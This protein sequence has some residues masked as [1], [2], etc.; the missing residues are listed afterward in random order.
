[1]VFWVVTSN[2][3]SVYSSEILLSTTEAEQCHKSQ[4]NIS[5]MFP[6]RIKFACCLIDAA[7]AVQFLSADVKLGIQLSAYL[8]TL[9]YF[10]NKEC[11]GKLCVLDHRVRSFKFCL[12]SAV[13]EK[14]RLSSLLPIC[15]YLVTSHLVI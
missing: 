15:L 5:C 10:G 12:L 1:M 2:V 11:L 3:K 13:N 6:L 9:R 8:E 7:K 4:H 14:S